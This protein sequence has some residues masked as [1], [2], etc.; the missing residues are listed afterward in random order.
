[1]AVGEDGG[2]LWRMNLYWRLEQEDDG[3]FAE[4]HSLSLSRDIPR[5]VGWIVKPFVRSMPRES[6][7][8][9]L[10]ATRLAVMNAK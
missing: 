7:E 4:C 1:M 5:G 3:V 6:L 10:Q 2:Y 8:K 9:S